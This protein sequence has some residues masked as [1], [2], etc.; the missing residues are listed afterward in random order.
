MTSYKLDRVHD[1]RE[2]LMNK[3]DQ[4]LAFIKLVLQWKE[5]NK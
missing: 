1:A 5:T 4:V 3:T 2:K